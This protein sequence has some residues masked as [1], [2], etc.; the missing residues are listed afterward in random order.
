MTEVLPILHKTLSNKSLT[1][2]INSLYLD[3]LASIYVNLCIYFKILHQNFENFI[4]LKTP[5]Q[6]LFHR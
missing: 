3:S 1:L 6:K 5:Q 2:L 4:F